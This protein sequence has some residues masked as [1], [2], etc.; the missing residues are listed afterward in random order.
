QHA[1][2]VGFGVEPRRVSTCLDLRRGR[3]PQAQIEVRVVGVLP[4]IFNLGIFPLSRAFDRQRS[5][6]SQPRDFPGEIDNVFDPQPLDDVPLRDRFGESIKHVPIEI[7][8]S[9]L[10]RGGLPKSAWMSAGMDRSGLTAVLSVSWV[11][12]LT[13]GDD[14]K[15]IVGLMYVHGLF[16]T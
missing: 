2:G 9:V 5:I 16:Q 14:R 8:I 11:M 12:G 6:P 15:P 13:P 10:R 7:W 1:R 4:R 3:R